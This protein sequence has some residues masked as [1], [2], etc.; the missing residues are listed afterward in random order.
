MRV[1]ATPPEFAGRPTS[2]HGFDRYDYLMDDRT[3]A[4]TPFTVSP[5]ERSGVHA[6]P[7]A[8][9]RCI[10]VAPKSARPGNPWSWQGCYWDHQPQ[11]EVEL[12]RRG[13][14][15]AFITPDPGP[16]WD[17]WYRWLTAEHG[18]SPRPA[19]VGMSKGGVNAYDW[20]TAN[21]TKVSCIYADN[22]AI[23]PAALAGLDALA[24]NDVA[25]LN[26]CGSLDFLLQ[27]NTLPIEG[28]YHAL[29]GQVTVMIKEGTAHHPHSLQ[30]AKPIADWIE[31]H[32]TSAPPEPFRLGGLSFDKTYLYSLSNHYVP[33]KAEQTFATCRG[34]GFTPCY[35]RY[36]AKPA[37]ES[38]STRGMTVVVPAI[39]APGKPWAMRA[40]AITRDATVDLALLAKGYHIVVPP[41]VDQ[42]GPDRKRWDDTYRLMVDAGFSPRPIVEGTGAGAGEAVAWAAT[43]PSRVGCFYAER[44][45]WHSL[46]GTAPSLDALAA[47]GK[48]G[49]AVVYAVNPNDPFESSASVGHAVAIDGDPKTPLTSADT[50][51]ILPYLTTRP[52]TQP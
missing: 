2:W 50:D 30:D 23:R 20:A 36:A 37:V 51:R 22:P 17:A 9:R 28:R 25:L 14:H 21:P 24:G 12:L 15:I 29:G 18:L 41:L 44:P 52:A 16:Q 40:T 13:F 48:A 46:M 1:R 5:E 35:A 27:R 42:S 43:D 49:V 45:I 19:F 8:H 3:F 33:L 38:W 7:P 34:P 47:L 10:V 39:A 4:V 6:P 31:Q 26:V 11:A 32:A